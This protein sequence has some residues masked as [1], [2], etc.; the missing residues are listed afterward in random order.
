MYVIFIYGPVA[1]GKYTIASALSKEL[2]IPLFHN[3]LTV[4]LVSSLFEFGSAPFISLREE[5]WLASFSTASIAKQSFIFTFAP[6]A[7]VSPNFIEQAV[8]VVC[9]SNGTVYFI[10]LTCAD[11]E[12]ERRI[13]EVSRADFG[14][15]RSAKIYRQLKSEGAFNFPSLPS[16]IV[17]IATDSISVKQ[18]VRI[19]K[20][21]V[22]DIT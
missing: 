22:D 2:G 14:K 15:L 8:S 19:I 1:S 21:R 5:I 12:I 20:A 7:T 13:G 18:A 9:S 11:I 16:P 10:E 17:T 4:D 3:H 6:E